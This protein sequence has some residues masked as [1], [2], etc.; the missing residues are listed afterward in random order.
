MKKFLL[1]IASLLL[2]CGIE[3]TAAKPEKQIVTTVF[4]TDIDCPHCAKKITD[5]IPF[6]KGVKDVKV[7]VPTK[8]VTISYDA[9]KTTQ[10]NLLKAFASIRVKVFKCEPQ[11]EQ[12]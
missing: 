11:N 4:T 8:K 6:E 3:T 10:D 12:K 2:F 1:I 5:S 9:S 7:D